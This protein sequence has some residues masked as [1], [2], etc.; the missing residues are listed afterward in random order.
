M[1]RVQMLLCTA[2]I[3]IALALIAYNPN[4]RAAETLMLAL[5]VMA[6]GVAPILFWLG[7]SKRDAIPVLH[8]QGVFYALSFG[9]GGV[10]EIRQN[11]ALG[12]INETDE[13]VALWMVLLGLLSLYVGYFLVGPAIYGKKTRWQWPFEFRPA[14]Y[15]L[16][17]AFIYPAVV[18][19]S[20]IV[21][22]EE[23]NTMGQV[24]GAAYEYVLFFLVYLYFSNQLKGLVRRL[25]L[26]I[27]I[28]CELVFNSGLASAQIGILI[29]MMIY[30]GIIYCA[31]KNRI[32]Y[33]FI[34]IAF[35][36]AALLQPIK[37]HVREIIWS[38]QGNNLTAIEKIQVF[39]SEG[40]SYYFEE[41]RYQQSTGEGVKMA[42][43][44]ANHLMVTAAIIRDTPERQ[45]F[46]YGETYLPF[47][48]K[49]IPRMIWPEKPVDNLGNRWARD[50]GYLHKK[51]YSTSFNL[52]WMSEMYMN[53]GVFGIIGI[54]FLI[55]LLFH[56]L[57][58][59][60]WLNPSTPTAFAFGVVT[61]IPL[62]LLESHL[63]T[64]LGGVIV[65]SMALFMVNLV[66]SRLTP[67][68]ISIRKYT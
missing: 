37:G 15:S 68:I 38:E 13:Q 31:T 33:L 19:A 59:N 16:V 62:C 65:H 61:G 66:I 46:S 7:D 54:N 52:P 49:W 45:P 67:N 17:V 39:L 14:A 47:F 24:I 4:D 22:S 2:L 41:S 5:G 63:S 8:L 48:T 40:Y 10:T 12:F 60:L 43:D 6:L 9:M 26:V 1:K 50:Y 29:H 53:F 58:V 35:S 23:A 55:G 32:P 28:P 11:N 30:L 36:M 27:A 20:L 57:S 44:R 3:L 18:L 21:R 34:I 56:T 51:D 64:V 25:F 42:H